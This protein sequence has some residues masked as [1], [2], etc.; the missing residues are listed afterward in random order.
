MTLRNGITAHPKGN[1]W[2]L[3]TEHSS[4]VIGATSEG[5]L[6]NLHWGGKL[7]TMEGPWTAAVPPERSSQ[8]PG[9]TA[10]TEEFPVFGGLRYGL[11]AL[12]AEFTE[13]HTRELDLM[14]TGEAVQQGTSLQLQLCDRVYKG[15]CVYLHYEVDIQHDIIR[16]WTSVKNGTKNN[17]EL[18][19][20]MSAGWHL[21]PTYMKRELVTLAGEWSAETQVQVHSLQPGLTQTIESLRGIPSAQAYPFYA[22][23]QANPE[24]QEAAVYF[25][26]LAWSGNWEIHLKTDIQGATVITGGIHHNDFSWTLKPGETFDTPY[27]ACGYSIDGLSGARRR[28]TSF[29][30]TRQHAGHLTNPVLYNSWEATG[31]HVTYDNQKR[32]AELAAT[33]GAELFVVDDGWFS[34]RRDDH[35][36]LGDWYPDDIKFP[37]G[38][39]PLSDYVHQLGMD[40]GLWFEPEMVNPDSDFYRNNPDCVYHYPDRPRS[41]ERNQLVLDLTRTDVQEYLFDRLSKLIDEVNIDYIKWDM[42]RPISEASGFFTAQAL[43]RNPREIW[44]RHVRAFYGLIERLKKTFPLL[45]IESCS[46]GGGRA[47]VQ[48][49]EYTDQCW[50]SDNTRPDARLR[51][52]YGASF[53]L[54]PKC[55]SCWVTDMP[56]D[57]S[58]MPLSFRFH[59]SFMGTLGVGANLTRYTADELQ[60]ACDWISVYKSLRFILQHGVIDWLIAPQAS[61][62]QMMASQTYLNDD[63]SVVLVFR[64]Q[65]P[66]WQPIPP[67]RVRHLEA[68]VMYTVQIWHQDP[69]AADIFSFSGAFLMQKGL[70][71]PYLTRHAYSSVVI[72]INKS[73]QGGS[74]REGLNG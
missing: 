73:G 63:E 37:H 4:Y 18:E 1:V 55:M 46:S 16:R 26:T 2:F 11:H 25:G 32:L 53:I 36:G 28:M 34:G 69:A 7:T 20:I 15:F 31:F 41:L 64:E 9:L 27:F 67:L 3:V 22:V 72:H 50:T 71:L 30:K 38:L 62:W 5:L 39:R 44:V 47:D 10:A 23:K 33:V 56:T 52:Q 43:K 14:W 19:K 17:I 66:F 74:R 57:E 21:P 70:D 40:F 13:T 42:N 60:L 51:I 45:R 6:L 48:I 8:D 65:S 68:S 35:A 59:V 58:L 54:P 24:S 61:Q 29:T 12:K 49:I